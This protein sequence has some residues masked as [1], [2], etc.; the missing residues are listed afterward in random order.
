MASKIDVSSLTLNPLEV[1][2]MGNFIIEKTF[3][4]P[5]LSSIHAV[6]TGLKMKEQIVFAAQM[7]LTGI[8]DSSCTRPNSGATSVLTQKYWEP[9]NVGDTLV[10]CNTDVNALFKAYYGKITK[11]AEKFDITGSELEQFLVVM[12]TETAMKAVWRIVWLGD[13]NVPEAGAAASGLKVAGNAVFY[14]HIDGIWAQ[15]FDGVTA[16]DIDRTTVKVSALNGQATTALQ[17]TLAAGDSVAV[18]EDMWAKADSRLRGDSAAQLLVSR[19]LFENYRQYLQG[20]GENFDISYTMDGMPSLKWNGLQ[21]IN[22]ENVWDLRLRADFVNNT[23][24]NAYW[25]PNRAVL[26]VPGNIPVGTLNESDMSEMDVWYEKKERQMY[27]AYGFTL[28]A[29]VLEPYMIV[30]AY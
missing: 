20:K 1:T 12:L 17:T 11:Y 8:L 2:E 28:D 19:E 27:T 6:Y 14:N 24:D 15:I 13:K 4:D 22:M 25:L 5:V 9:A 10:H 30:A 21:V 29:K 18:F 7:G 23:T 26:T 3:Q 16:G